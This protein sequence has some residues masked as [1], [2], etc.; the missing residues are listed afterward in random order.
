MSEQAVTFLRTLNNIVYSVSLS[1]AL[2]ILD[3]ALLINPVAPD[4]STHE[5]R[6]A[7][8][9]K[10]TAAMQFIRNDQK[11]QAIKEIRTL[12]SCGLK[13]AKDA[14]DVVYAEVDPRGYNRS[15]EALSSLRAKLSGD[16]EYARY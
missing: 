12:A 2:S 9:R 14:V 11:I 15:D 16:S 6:V 4:Y 1:E 3:A 13:E 7:L 8:V 5:A 10:S